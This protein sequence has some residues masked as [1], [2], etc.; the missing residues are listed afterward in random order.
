MQPVPLIVS[1][2]ILKTP[3]I[4]C[5]INTRSFGG[6]HKNFQKLRT[7]DQDIRTE[8]AVS[9]PLH[10]PLTME[11]LDVGFMRMPEDIKKGN[12]KTP[13]RKREDGENRDS[14]EEALHEYAL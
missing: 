14:K 10:N 9:V 4:F 6:Q 13:L 3:A 7:V 12:G 5:L 11:E 2:E 8:D 1:A